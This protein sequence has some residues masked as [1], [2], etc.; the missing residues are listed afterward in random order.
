MRVLGCMECSG[1]SVLDLR[2]LTILNSFA[3]HYGSGAYSYYNFLRWLFFSNLLFAVLLLSFVIIPQ[4]VWRATEDGRAD[5]SRRSAARTYCLTAA[6][7]CTGCQES[8]DPAIVMNSTN[9]DLYANLTNSSMIS[10]TECSVGVA[11]IGLQRDAIR[12]NF[13]DPEWFLCPRDECPR[14]VL[15][16]FNNFLSG[17][18]LFADS[19]LFIGWY[20][21]TP[22]RWPTIGAAYDMPMAYLLTAAVVYGLSLILIVIR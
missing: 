19:E 20:T 4:F 1:R 18:G 3:G 6:T 10:V 15:K 21:N 7:D 17:E 14:N 16:C 22:I 9:S 2:M 12:G 11:H 5:A 8:C 13:S